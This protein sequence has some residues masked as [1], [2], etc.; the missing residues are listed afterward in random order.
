MRSEKN[1]ILIR[2]AKWLWDNQLKKQAKECK[3]QAYENHNSWSAR[4]WKNNNSTKS[5]RRVHSGRR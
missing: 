2:H 4:H 5:S 1:I 3:K